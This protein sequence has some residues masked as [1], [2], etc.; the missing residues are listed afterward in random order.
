M[1]NRR[2]HRL[3]RVEPLSG[4][5]RGLVLVALVLT[6]LFTMAVLPAVAQSALPNM[7]LP[8]TGGTQF[9]RDE[10]VR[11]GWRVQRNHFTGHCRLLDHNQIRRAWSSRPARVEG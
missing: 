5:W 10:M 9:W 11:S 1:L 3:D 4:L 8:T 7:Q 2:P 6:S